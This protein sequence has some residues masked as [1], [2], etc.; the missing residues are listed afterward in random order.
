MSNLIVYNKDIVNNTGI[1]LTNPT[2]DAGAYEL[3][4]QSGGGAYCVHNFETLDPDYL[5]EM[6]EPDCWYP[7]DYGVLDVDAK[8]GN[9]S[10]AADDTYVGYYYDPDIIDEVELFPPVT[11]EFWFKVPTLVNPFDYVE[12]VVNG[13]KRVDGS[14]VNSYFSVY[15]FYNGADFIT[16][17]YCHD[18]YDN[19]ILHWEDFPLQFTLEEYH[20]CAIVVLSDRIKIFFDGILFQECVS[21]MEDGFYLQ[22]QEF[23][24]STNRCIG[25]IDAF[26]MSDYEKYTSNFDPPTEPPTPG[27][28]PG[29][30]SW[31]GG[32]PVEIEDDGTY[33]LTSLPIIPQCT[34][35][36]IVVFSELGA[37]GT[38]LVR[39]EE[40]FPDNTGLVDIL[41]P[42][43]YLLD[44]ITINVPTTKIV[45]DLYV[46]NFYCDGAPEEN[47]IITGEGTS[48]NIISNSESINVSNTTLSDSQASGSAQFLSLIENGCVDDG[49]NSGWIFLL[50]ADSC[51]F[52]RFTNVQLEKG[53]RLKSE[54]ILLNIH[55]ITSTTEIREN[56]F[57][58]YINEIANVV[59]PPA[60]VSEFNSLVLSDP[61]LCIYDRI[62]NEIV[63]DIDVT[64]LVKK[65]I[66]M[67]DWVSGNSIMFVLKNS[68]P[69]Y[70][71][72]NDFSDDPIKSSMLLS[73]RY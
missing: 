42:G 21:P 30:V 48:W 16:E 72:I 71:K 60:T 3:S 53:E 13:W 14:W 69:F 25:K 23:Y 66:N 29:S 11:F 24:M 12:F 63:M 44:S 26:K 2:G 39:V 50:N 49:N 67:D 20:F 54:S 61:I 4:F 37:G 51:I 34:V 64:E 65:I 27:G 22:Q 5:F 73:H 31:G 6:T 56:K 55:I 18:F 68:D 62:Y 40:E 1:T 36:A 38:D 15:N 35:D 70:L 58:L 59:S 28:L 7:Y 52:L 47:N 32:E 8:F 45:G 57:N 43:D 46:N 10:Y 33:T 17:M 19:V 9:Y 41:K